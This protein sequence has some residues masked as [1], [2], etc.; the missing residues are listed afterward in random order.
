[1]THLVF[2]KRSVNA[3]LNRIANEVDERKYRSRVEVLAEQRSAAFCVA[4]GWHAGR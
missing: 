2:G 4:A 3:L 1:M